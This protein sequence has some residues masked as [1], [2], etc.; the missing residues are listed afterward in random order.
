MTAAQGYLRFPHISGDLL[1][2]VAENDVWLAGADGGQARRLT[3]EAVPVTRPRLSADGTLLAWMSRRH[4][5]PE[6]FLI[7][8]AGGIPRQLTFFG[9]A[10]TILLGFDP[11]GRVLVA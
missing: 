4:G 2:F 1:T 5:E 7:P 6:V 3:A 10:S 9:H 8:V 11:D